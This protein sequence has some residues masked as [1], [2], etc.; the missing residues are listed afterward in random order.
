MRIVSPEKDNKAH[1]DHVAGRQIQ[2][3][4][5]TLEGI[6]FLISLVFGLV[7]VADSNYFM[8]ILVAGLGC[9]VSWLSTRFLQGFGEMVED[10]AANLEVNMRI[11]DILESQEKRQQSGTDTK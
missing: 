1:V 2:S 10:T 9:Y 8:A 7:F 4:A 6:G 5:N 3:V 11:L